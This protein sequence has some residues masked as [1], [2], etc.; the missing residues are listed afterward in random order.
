LFGGRG[1]LAEAVE[2]VRAAKVAAILD[3]LD[4]IPQELRSPALRALSDQADF[5]VVVLELGGPAFPI[6]LSDYGRSAASAH[7]AA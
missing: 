4:E 5:R 1:G 6:T 7:V 2:L 3:G